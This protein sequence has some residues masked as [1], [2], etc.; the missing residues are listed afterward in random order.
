MSI[1]PGR[2]ANPLPQHAVLWLCHAVPHIQGAFREQIAAT[3]DQCVPAD[4]LTT[5]EAAM[6]EPLSDVLHAAKQVGALTGKLV[7]VTG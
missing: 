6:A 4:G 5:K 1:L 7:L 3:I 2:R